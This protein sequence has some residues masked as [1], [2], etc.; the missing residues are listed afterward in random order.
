MAF[1]KGTA[2]RFQNPHLV[3][4]TVV[5]LEEG[6]TATSQLA[7]QRQPYGDGKCADSARNK[8]GHCEA[9]LQDWIYH[10]TSPNDMDGSCA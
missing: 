8:G 4:M 9:L 1:L 5:A 10:R 7:A 2:S 6:L 3:H